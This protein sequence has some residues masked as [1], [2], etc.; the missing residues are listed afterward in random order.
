MGVLSKA[1]GRHP[2]MVTVAAALAATAATAQ[3]RPSLNRSSPG[4]ERCD[5]LHAYL[6]RYD[7]ESLSQHDAARRLRADV[8]LALCARGDY[9][10][11]IRILET[12][13]RTAG[14]PPLSAK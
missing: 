8:A 10:Q 1:I 13:T 14:L 6:Y 7:I 3:D 5:E 9:D 11:G 12:E 2:M 4:A